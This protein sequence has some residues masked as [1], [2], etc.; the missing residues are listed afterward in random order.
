MYADAASRLPRRAAVCRGVPAPRRSA[1]ARARVGAGRSHAARF[2]RAHGGQ[3]GRD[4]AGRPGRHRLVRCRARR[5]HG[6]RRG[7]RDG[8]L[9]RAIEGQ[10]R[11]R[12]HRRAPSAPVDRLRRRG[13]A[14]GTSSMPSPPWGRPTG[15]DGRRGGSRRHGRRCRARSR[16]ARLGGVAA[17]AARDRPRPRRLGPR[18]AL[19]PPLAFARRRRP[20]G[21][22]RARALERPRAP[23][24]RD[25]AA[26]QRPA[27]ARLRRAADGRGAARG[28][29]GLRRARSPRRL[30]PVPGDAPAAGCAGDLPA[31][32]RR[33]PRA[34]LDRGAG[35]AR[36]RRGRG[37]ARAREV[38]RALAA[39][40]RGA[41]LHAPPADRRRRRGRVRRAVVAAAARPARPAP[42][43]AGRPGAGHLVPQ[44]LSRAGRRARA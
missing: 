17:R 10:A 20:P 27:P 36:R 9:V 44:P 4:R 29:C 37:R 42:A 24:R 12:V 28:R 23:Q 40:R 13:R 2:P 1:R 31:R 3:R 21:R 5:L 25:A 43:A 41:R 34:A 16:R 33:D 18:H 19:V 14:R 7:H 32:R 26:P 30:A 11:D 38:R 35:G 6:A 15:E 39:G 22:A 8:G